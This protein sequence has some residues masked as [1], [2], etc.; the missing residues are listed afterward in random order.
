MQAVPWEGNGFAVNA[1]LA[2]H[3]GMEGKEENQQIFSF[4]KVKLVHF[5]LCCF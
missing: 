3:L 5:W 4:D 2:M 1:F